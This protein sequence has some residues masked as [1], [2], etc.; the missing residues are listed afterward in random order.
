[1]VERVQCLHLVYMVFV[2]DDGYEVILIIIYG[3]CV[4]SV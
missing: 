2:R 1:M 3:Q 4:E